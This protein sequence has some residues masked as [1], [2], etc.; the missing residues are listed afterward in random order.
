M[1]LAPPSPTSAN[2]I[3]AVTLTTWLLVSAAE[4][5]LITEACAPQDG[6]KAM[7]IATPEA[8]M[9]CLARPTGP[10]S[11]SPH[12]QP[13]ER[14]PGLPGSGKAGCAGAC[15]D[16]TE[17]DGPWNVLTGIRPPSCRPY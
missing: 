9:Q 6:P 16:P 11:S 12:R 5:E 14:S 10:T 4:P 1:H 8:R 3:K 7:A 17:T 15:S 2:L 13:P